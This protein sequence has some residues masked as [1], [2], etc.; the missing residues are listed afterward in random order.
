MLPEGEIGG[1]I[2]RLFQKFLSAALRNRV[3]AA[4]RRKHSLAPSEIYKDAVALLASREFEA[5]RHKLVVRVTQR[6]GAGAVARMSS[7]VGIAFPRLKIGALHENR[8]PVQDLL[9]M[10][11]DIA[12]EKVVPK[13]CYGRRMI[14]GFGGVDNPY[15]AVFDH[16]KRTLDL[17]DLPMTAWLNLEGA[18]V[19]Y[20]F[21]GTIEGTW[22]QDLSELAS[23]LDLADIL[24]DAR[25]IGALDLLRENLA[26]FTFG[27]PTRSLTKFSDGEAMSEARRRIEEAIVALGGRRNT[28]GFLFRKKDSSSAMRTACP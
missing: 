23:L 21:R 9:T 28:G 7:T 20:R 13:L 5:G 15:I 10:D 18:S 12:A 6:R 16:A 8:Y 27:D 22:R 26:D 4:L 14:P 3:R 25:E 19:E 1:L 24:N 2:E 11:M 17:R